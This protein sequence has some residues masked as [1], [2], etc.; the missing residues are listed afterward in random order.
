L[1]VLQEHTFTPV[2]SN[3]EVR[4]DVRIVAATNASLEQLSLE[5]RFRRDLYY[6]LNAL[7]LRVQPLRERNGDSLLLAEHFLAECAMRFGRGE[8]RLDHSTITWFETY[9]WPGNVR[10]LENLICREYLLADG[11]LI[12]IAPPGV[13]TRGCNPR[14]HPGAEAG[15]LD[16][17]R[18]KAQAIADFER[19]YLMRVITA[20]RGNVTRAAVMAGKERRAFGKLL[21]K[22]GI[23][24]LRYYR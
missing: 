19:L 10:E 23:D 3:R 5:R 2:G 21:K 11:P 14:Q 6:R 1:R 20:S 24:K 9:A 12:A 7:Y 16:F 22:H 15:A 17:S 4:A 8:K 18:A 13:R